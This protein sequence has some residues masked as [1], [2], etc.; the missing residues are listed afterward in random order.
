M[1]EY[2][3]R[4]GSSVSSLGIVGFD[5]A[6]RFNVVYSFNVPSGGASSVSVHLSGIGTLKGSN[7]LI[8]IKISNTV[9]AY[10]NAGAGTSPDGSGYLSFSSSA[11]YNGTITASVNLAPGTYYV[12]VY[13]V[14][15]STGYWTQWISGAAGITTSGSYT[16][17]TPGTV[18]VASIT[19]NVSTTGAVVI[20]MNNPGYRSLTA[21]FYYG[22]TLLATSEAFT[23]SLSYTC[24]RSWLAQNISVTSIVITVVISYSGGSL[25]TIFTLNADAAMKP[26]I[27]AGAYTASRINTG[28][29]DAI[30]STLTK[31]QIAFRRA[32][33]DM[34]ATAGAA[35]RELWIEYNGTQY[36]DPV[37]ADTFRTANVTESGY[38]RLFCK[39]SRGRIGYTDYS[40]TAIAYVQPTLKNVSVIRCNSGGTAQQTGTYFKVSA[41]GVC[42]TAGL[43]GNSVTISVYSKESGSTTYSSKGTYASG[44]GYQLYSGLNSTL[45]YTVKLVVSDRAGGSKSYEYD[46]TFEEWMLCYTAAGD[47]CGVGQAPDSSHVL[48]IPATW[49]FLSG[50]ARFGKERM[51]LVRG[52]HYGTQ[53]EMEAVPSPIE[54][55]VFFVISS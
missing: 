44:S 39:D 49:E 17:P 23:T 25:S 55:Q 51:V 26:V 27:P 18:S 50:G 36:T 14:S 4:N 21:S 12:T 52:K 32:S 2:W 19:Q 1:A 42:S 24:P 28:S 6:N 46:L 35:I 9:S 3:Y 40:F 48:Q 38:V 33:I 41:T 37:A 47:G 10:A 8:G 29:I 16:P 30:I 7:N 43:S 11:L 5:G 15:G 34:S 54:G 20:Q 53:V 31:I 45:A 13:T 22:S